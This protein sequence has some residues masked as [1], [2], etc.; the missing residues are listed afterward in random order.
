MPECFILLALFLLL[1]IVLL[2]A[3]LG[4]E[5][6]FGPA[7]PT[8]TAVVNLK[9]LPD[10][11]PDTDKVVLFWTITP[12]RD[13]IA[14]LEDDAL[15]RGDSRPSIIHDD[16][17][18]ED[19]RQDQFT[20]IFDNPEPGAWQLSCAFHTWEA[21]PERGPTVSWR[22]GEALCEFPLN[23]LDHGIVVTFE[24]TSDG[25]G[26]WQVQIPENGCP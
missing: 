21:V 19:L 6:T 16:L 9:Y 14:P 25:Q 15:L 24:I 23:E 26:G 1:P 4:C 17:T 20:Y 5:A 10:A 2:F 13:D 22:W 18:N 12:L 7:E 8:L 11:P 3:F